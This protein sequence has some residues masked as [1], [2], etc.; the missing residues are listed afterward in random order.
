M[1]H[2]SLFRTGG[3]RQGPDTSFFFM[4]DWQL[5]QCDHGSTLV[6]HLDSVGSIDVASE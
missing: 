4:F 5:A 1:T 3:W 6:Q 2:T